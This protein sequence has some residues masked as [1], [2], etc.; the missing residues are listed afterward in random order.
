MIHAKRLKHLSGTPAQHIDTP[1]FCR[2]GTK[3]SRYNLS[4][5]C[6]MHIPN[7]KGDTYYAGPTNRSNRIRKSPSEEG[8]S[9]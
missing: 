7:D 2:C 1:R 6:Y 8:P 5:Y 4:D 3:L 9:R